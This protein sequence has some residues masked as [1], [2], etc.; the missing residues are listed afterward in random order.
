M[1]S[2]PSRLQETGPEEPH[3]IPGHHITVAGAGGRPT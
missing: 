1:A 3:A 2:E